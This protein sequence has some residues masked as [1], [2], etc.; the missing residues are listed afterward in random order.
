M[1]RQTVNLI[2]DSVQILYTF[3]ILEIKPHFCLSNFMSYLICMGPRWPS[4]KVSA[5]EP[6]ASRFET[7]FHRRYHPI[8]PCH[9]PDPKDESLRFAAW[10]GVR[11]ILID[12]RV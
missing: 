5:S 9:T 7:R 1:D 11:R 3:T 10:V 2:M 8:P 6:K 12:P 4:G